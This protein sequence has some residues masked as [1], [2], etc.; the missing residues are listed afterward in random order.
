MAAPETPLDELRREIDGIDDALHDLMMRRAELVLRI[1]RAKAAAGSAGS[2]LR[3]GR[4]ASVLR[5]LVGRHHGPL[6]AG[7]VVRI[8]RELMSAALALQGPFAVA[9]HS[10][11]G[12]RE[13]ARDHFGA[14]TP[15]LPH[16]SGWQVLRAVAEGE[17]TV[18]V[19]PLPT[20]DEP[21][22]WWRHL[23]GKDAKAP[24]IV[25]RLP[26]AG[27]PPRG[28]AEAFAVARGPAE[29][30]GRDRSLI[31]IESAPQ[32]SV[33]T[34]AGV[35]RAGGLEPVR[36]LAWRDPQPG[37]AWLHLVELDGF[38]APDDVRLGR[39]GQGGEMLR[40]LWPVGGYAVPFTAAELAATAGS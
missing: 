20:L 30:S 40:R 16:D 2:P 23:L 31:A 25:A 5:R 27:L 37:A 26:F 29:P 28:D 11:P 10:A 14:L 13:L 4:E 35:L 18:G 34:L 21:D 36:S 12:C 24:R 3:P 17:A 33:S 8:W 19:L 32:T 6:P 1:G 38:V 9:V 22:P 15:L 39:L 7:V